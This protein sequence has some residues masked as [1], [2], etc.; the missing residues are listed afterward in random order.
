[1]RK[2]VVIIALLGAVAALVKRAR[3]Q[4]AERDVWKSATKEPDLR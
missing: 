2:P 1:M 3:A 4:R